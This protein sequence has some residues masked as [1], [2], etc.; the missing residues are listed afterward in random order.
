MEDCV[1]NE[2]AVRT[3]THLA[4]HLDR[5]RDKAIQL[6]KEFATGDRGY[7]TPSEDEEVLGL[8]VSYHKSRAALFEL[9]DSVRRRIGKPHVEQLGEFAVAY[10]AVLILVDAARF[11]RELFAEDP[12][13]RRKLNEAQHRFGIEEGSFDAIQMS[14]TNPNNAF[15]IRDATRFYD[16]YRERLI[17]LATSHVGLGK[18]L[19]VI[20]KLG[21]AA[22]ISVGGYVK[23]RLSDRQRD[24]RDRIFMGNVVSV[25]YAIQ[26]WGSRL[27]SQLKTSP[28]HV[29]QLPAGI[30]KSLGAVLVPGDVLATRKDNAMTNYF[31][32]GYWPHVAMY[33]GDGRVVE[34][35]KD[36]V[37]ERALKSPFG[38]D[39]IAIIR[40][41]LDPAAVQ[42]AIDRA[43]THVGKPYDFDFDF[44][45]ADRMVCT[46]V[47]YRSYEGIEGFY[48]DLVRRAGRQTLSA[49]DLLRLALRDHQF[50]IVASYCKPFGEKLMMDAETKAVLCKTMAE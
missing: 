13:V 3:V 28:G 50:D 41:R 40:P 46:E 37:Q 4:D 14:L 15:A 9:I 47:V 22:R 12:L 49:E 2:A 26:E 18:I 39:A 44:T 30:A 1:P 45:R 21:G 7:F 33:V 11:L 5:L 29:P 35:L 10:A 43:H 48:F 8:W 38:N 34:A 32:P 42:R 17:N 23:A 6:K 36:G 24:A 20:D 25:V 19:V 27:L 16:D 31:L